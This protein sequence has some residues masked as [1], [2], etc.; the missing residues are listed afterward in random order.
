MSFTYVFHVFL[1][2][3]QGK[4]SC[5]VC[6]DAVLSCCTSWLI[7]ETP[8]GPWAAVRDVNH[9]QQAPSFIG[10]NMGQLVQ[11]FYFHLICC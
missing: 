3:A 8:I 1:I 11:Q 10:Q 6:D 7:F 5:I 4:Q 2:V 9:A